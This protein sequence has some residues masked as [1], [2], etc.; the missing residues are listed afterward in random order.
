M[1]TQRYISTS[2]WDDRWIRSLNP[3]DRYLYL[4]LMTNPLTNIAGV[5]QITI[6]R[7][8]FDTGYDDRT[9][10]P[11]L[12]KF[13]NAGKAY[14][15]ENEWMILPAWPEHQQWK[16]RSKIRDGIVAILE[17]LTPELLG[18]MK[19]NGYRYPIDTLS[20]PY[21]YHPNYS[22][23]DSDL[24][25]DSDPEGDTHIPPEDEPLNGSGWEAEIGLPVP[26]VP[27]GDPLVKL[28]VDTLS[29]KLPRTA[30]TD[31]HGQYDA[32]REI[33]GRIRSLLPDTPMEDEDDLAKAIIAT[34]ARKKAGA[35]NAKS[36]YWRDAEFTPIRLKQR[37]PEVVSSL[38]ETYEREAE[39]EADDA[40]GEAALA[41]LRGDR[42]AD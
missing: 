15:Y 23:T 37:F 19:L 2:F 36:D 40:E 34:F 42:E 13:A 21:T 41:R 12:E 38:A 31:L 16:R 10:K 18:F 22:D 33:A 35:K 7:I 4:Y 30:W 9:L 6:D 14:H 24:D 17:T 1:A 26:S 11:M 8:A 3:S 27:K 29:T 32:A 39:R 20:V 25:T 28:I 5:Y